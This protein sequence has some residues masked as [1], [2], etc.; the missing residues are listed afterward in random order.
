MKINR[1]LIKPRITEK[2]LIK[3]KDSVYLFE[4]NINADKNQVKK[5]VE[6][7]FAVQVLNVKIIIRKGKMRRVGRRMKEKRISDIKLAYIKLR[8]GKIDLFPQT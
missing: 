5:A 2:G 7:L 6:E 4:V 3:A 1:I 8:K